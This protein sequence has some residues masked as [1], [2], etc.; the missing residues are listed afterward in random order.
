MGR[1]AARIGDMIKHDSPHCHA[2]IH[3]S[4]PVPTPMAHPP[5]ALEIKTGAA[6]VRIGG[7]PAAR[8]TDQSARCM[9]LACVPAGPGIIAKGSTT[10]MIE[11][12]PAARVDDVTSHPSCV[13]PI[14]SPLGKVMRP[15]CATVRIGG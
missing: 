10:V 8:V 11:K 14:P 12:K 9:L 2:P 3:P 1:P 5:V 6:T 15:G 13:A 4:A 7:K